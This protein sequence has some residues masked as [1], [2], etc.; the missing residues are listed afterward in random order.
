MTEPVQLT[1]EEEERAVR[2]AI[3]AACMEGISAYL[4]EVADT[5]VAH[6]MLAITATDLRAMAAAMQNRVTGQL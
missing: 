2:D 5:M 4:N 1:P 6:N 3:Q